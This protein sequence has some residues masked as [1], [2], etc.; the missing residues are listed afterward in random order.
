[1]H[2][3]YIQ[4]EHHSDDMY[5]NKPSENAILELLKANNLSLDAI[6]PH[7]FGDFDERIYKKL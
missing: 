4:L 7:G 5:E 3:T 2:P 6:V 1:V